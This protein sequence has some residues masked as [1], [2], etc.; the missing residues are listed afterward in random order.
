M[1]G[2][3][4][5][6][7]RG[8]GRGYYCRRWVYGFDRPRWGLRRWYDPWYYDEPVSRSEEKRFISEEI[9]RVKE[10]LDYLNGRLEKLDK[11]LG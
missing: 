10:Y 1:F 8:F 7:G 4:R 2:Y 3:G 9:K 6:F 11:E 5:G